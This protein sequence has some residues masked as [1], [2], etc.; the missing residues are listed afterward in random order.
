E[1]YYCLGKGAHSVGYHLHLVRYGG[2]HWEDHIIFRDYL[3]F[4]PDVAEDYGRLKRRLESLYGSDRRSYT[5]GKT[6]FIGEVISKAR[7]SAER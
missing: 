2:R 6:C 1:W 4:H 7:N 5:D 3:R